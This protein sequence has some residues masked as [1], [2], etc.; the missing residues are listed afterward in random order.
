MIRYSAYDTGWQIRLHTARR[1]L[2]LV[3]FVVFL[4]ALILFAR[5]FA[6]SPYGFTQLF[7]R[8]TAVSLASWLVCIAAYG[9]Y[10]CRLDSSHGL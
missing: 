1:V 3:P 5:T 4:V 10:R 6:Q 9:I 2:G 7:I 8:V